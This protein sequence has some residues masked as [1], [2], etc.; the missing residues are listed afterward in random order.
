MR[1][2]ELLILIEGE[3]DIE[4]DAEA[5]LAEPLNL[6]ALRRAVAAAVG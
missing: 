5:L 3:L 4:L 1:L 2:A 6:G